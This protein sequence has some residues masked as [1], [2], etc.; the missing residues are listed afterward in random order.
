MAFDAAA[1]RGAFERFTIAQ[2]AYLQNQRLIRHT[3]GAMMPDIPAELENRRQI[4]TEYIAAAAQLASLVDDT[5]KT[6]E[7]AGIDSSPLVRLRD[8]LR[9][10]T[11]REAI[12]ARGVAYPT[13]AAE[14]R[15]ILHNDFKPASAVL[16]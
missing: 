16:L 7:E 2:T 6:A 10:I 11:L 13:P 8:T 1:W 4:N 14:A 3:G 9:P 12:K 5:A 15:A